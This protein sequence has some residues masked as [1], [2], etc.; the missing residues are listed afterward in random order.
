MPDLLPASRVSTWRIIDGGA[1]Q[2]AEPTALLVRWTVP[3]HL[4]AGCLFQ[5]YISRRLHAATAQPTDRS[6]VVSLDSPP[7]RS[8]LDVQ[9]IAVAPAHAATDFAHL[10]PANPLANR[11]RLRWPRIQS[12]HPAATFQLFSNAGHGEIDFASPLLPRP[13]PLFAPGTKIGLGFGAFGRHDFGFDSARAP[14]LGLSLFGLDQFGFDTDAVEWLSPPLPPG[15]F[16]FAL[17]CYDALGNAA[18][19]IETAVNILAPPAPLAAC[20]LALDDQQRL[21]ITVN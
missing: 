7:A 14:G 2:P 13:L 8:L 5:V 15:S 11:V 20:Q 12:A 4:P 18:P 10:L 3:N 9:V 19:P 16:R 6:L 17:V 21:V 1:N